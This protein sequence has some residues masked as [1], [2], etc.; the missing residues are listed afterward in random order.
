MATLQELRDALDYYVKAG[1]TNSARQIAAAIRA[2]KAPPE[3]VEDPGAAQTLLIGAGRTFDR[4]GK[5][6]KQMVLAAKDD[7]EGLAALKADAEEDDRLYKPLQEAR[8]W[9]TGIGEALPSVALPGGSA[10]TVLGTA[11]RMAV[12]GALPGALE[13]GSVG[14]R[15]ARA[16]VGAAA[17]AATPLV[18]KGAVE[19]AKGVGRTARAAA[20]PFTE[21]GRRQIAARVLA[22]AVSDTP[23]AIPSLASATQLVPGSAPTAAQVAGSGGLAALERSV[24]ATSPQRVDAYTRRA[25]EQAA[26]RV[27]A[28]RGVAGDEAMLEAAK[29]TREE[30]AKKS[31]KHAYMAGV[32]KEAAESLAPQ[33]NMLLERPSIRNAMDTARNHAA[34]E[35][36]NIDSF[37]SVQGLHFLKEALDDE[38]SSLAAKPKL[39]RRLLQTKND[40]M[41]VLE[42]I[43]PEYK[44]ASERYARLSKP[45]NRMEVGQAVLEKIEPALNDHGALLSQTGASAARALRRADALTRQ[46][47]GFR[48]AKYNSVLEPQHR[49]TVDAIMADL[50]RGANAQSLGAGR[51][52]DT[53]Q[54]LAMNHIAQ[55]SGAPRAMNFLMD[56]PVMSRLTRW[57]HRDSDE[58]VR[59][60]LAQTLLSPTETARFI[61]EARTRVASLPNNGLR[62]P[63]SRGQQATSV[64][65]G[66]ARRLPLAAPMASASNS[67]NAALDYDPEAQSYY[68]DE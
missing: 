2:A 21:S 56:L 8:P 59:D 61:R 40:L 25:R 23:G 15:A 3:E 62:T 49:A 26:A 34:E 20:Q 38:I 1:D 28:L 16:G 41:S 68:L 48:G 50:A 17:G 39:Q 36:L 6:A 4:I 10:A 42:E 35:G 30:A 52:S 13:Y 46:A 37:G 14:D 29:T 60:L 67:V 54:K 63:L 64:L 65:K 12:A 66:S 27:Q 55:A 47:T 44:A 9:M 45:I 43:A 31:F 57:A 51:G 18:L 33:I 53:V 58:A 22:D 24:S 5:G 19:L 32:D 11:G 7:Q